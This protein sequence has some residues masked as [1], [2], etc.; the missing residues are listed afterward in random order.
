MNAT[1]RKPHFVRP[2]T[3]IWLALIFLTAITYSIGDAGL[4]GT[5]VMLTVL[6]ITF[7]KSQ[8][9]ASFFMGLRKSGLMWRI[10]MGSY[11]VVITSMIAVAYLIASK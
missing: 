8:M 3:L 6:A 4:G 11:L 10:I 5:P 2:C 7:I 9:I 1:P